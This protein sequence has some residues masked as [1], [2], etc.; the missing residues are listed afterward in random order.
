[1]EI[2]RQRFEEWNASVQNSNMKLTIA[3]PAEMEPKD[4]VTPMIGH[5]KSID[6]KKLAQAMRESRISQ[7]YDTIADQLSVADED[8]VKP[9]D[10]NAIGRLFMYA[11]PENNRPILWRLLN[12][13]CTTAGALI[14]KQVVQS[15]AT[16][17]L[18]SVL[19]KLLERIPIDGESDSE[20]GYDY[21]LQ[22]TIDVNKI[23][24]DVFMWDP[25]LAQFSGPIDV[26]E[27]SDW[28]SV[29]CMLSIKDGTTAYLLGKAQ[30]WMWRKNEL[31]YEGKE[32]EK[33]EDE[34]GPL[35]M[36]VQ[37]FDGLPLHRRRALEVKNEEEEDSLNGSSMVMRQLIEQVVTYPAEEDTLDSIWSDSEDEDQFDESEDSE[38]EA[39]TFDSATEVSGADV[40]ESD[41][42]EV[43][44]DSE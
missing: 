39:G 43:N 44:R 8:K 17:L 28:L 20:F 23:L 16:S 13:L 1:M 26:N 35:T 34:W 7:D 14:G 12:D 10:D 5:S 33:E 21:A 22:L 3:S 38:A 30:P 36:F 19:R 32:E 25:S 41:W 31:Q 9:E 2:M 24:A 37:K 18:S 42:S 40:T 29:N 4:T 6:I 15:D 27:F 11:C